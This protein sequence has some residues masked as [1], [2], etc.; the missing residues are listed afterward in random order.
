MKSN[1]PRRR[2]IIV[3][4]GL[5]G[6]A[7]YPFLRR[8]SLTAFMQDNLFHGIWFGVCIGIMIVGL[9]GKAQRKLAG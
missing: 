9:F 1:S 3:A 6:M 7:S 4:I 5:L 2:Y 8:L